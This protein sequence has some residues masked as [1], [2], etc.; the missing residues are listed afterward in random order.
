MMSPQTSHS[1][2]QSPHRSIHGKLDCLVNN[3]G[4]QFV[5][6]LLDF[7]MKQA[8]AMHDINVV[9]AFSPVILAGL[10]YP[11]YIGK[12]PFSSSFHIRFSTYTNQQRSKSRS[13]QQAETSSNDSA[14]RN[15]PRDTWCLEYYAALPV[16]RMSAIYRR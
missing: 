8:R 4:Q 1:R 13:A 7:D 5:T 14:V 16:E 10:M 12:I 6:P 3:S 15:I 9:Q 11:P 2:P